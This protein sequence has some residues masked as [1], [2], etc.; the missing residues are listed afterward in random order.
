[1]SWFLVLVV[2]ALLIV[3]RQVVCQ[4]VSHILMHD[5]L[6]LLGCWWDIL[7]VVRLLL[8]R[9]VHVAWRENLVLILAISEERSLLLR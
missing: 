5:Y 7:R 1:M 3:L 6:V 4:V 9:H 2:R 8:Y